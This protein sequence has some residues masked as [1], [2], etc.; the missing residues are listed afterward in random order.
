LQEGAE[1]AGQEET[2]REEEGS[3]SEDEWEG[4]WT[5]VLRED[6]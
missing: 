4:D 3:E 5:E 6:V 1:A 2:E